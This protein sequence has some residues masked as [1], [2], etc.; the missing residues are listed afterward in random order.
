MVRKVLLTDRL[1]LITKGV[2]LVMSL[3]LRFLVPAEALKYF[4]V[5]GRLIRL[6]QVLLL[7]IFTERVFDPLIV[8]ESRLLSNVVLIDCHAISLRVHLFK[9]NARSLANEDDGSRKC[10]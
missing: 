2:S 6:P 4:S 1:A 7:H 3:L 5:H 10:Q 9:F 8:S